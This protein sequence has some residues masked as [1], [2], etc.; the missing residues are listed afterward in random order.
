MDND[1]LYQE[2]T[3]F[4][5]FDSKFPYLA[6]LKDDEIWMSVIPH[7]INTM[8]KPVTWELEFPVAKRFLRLLLTIRLFM[9]ER[10]VFILFLLHRTS[11]LL[12][13]R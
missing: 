11:F 6:L 3:P 7:E 9:F 5:F 13:L 10:A 8:K 2:H 1:E 12:V 4:G